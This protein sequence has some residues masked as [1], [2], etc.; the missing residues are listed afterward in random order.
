MRA[1]SLQRKLNPTSGLWALRGHTCRGPTLGA[2]THP[3][4]DARPGRRIWP[5]S[6]IG[7][8]RPGKP[9]KCSEPADLGSHMHIG[10]GGWERCRRS[11]RRDEAGAG[12]RRWV[13]EQH[14][15]EKR[16]RLLGDVGL[17]K[18]SAKSQTLLHSSGHQRGTM[19]FA[20]RGAGSRRVVG[21]NMRSSTRPPRPPSL[22]DSG[23]FRI[24][25]IFGGAGASESHGEIRLMPAR[26]M[27]A[28][29]G[30]RRPNFTTMYRSCKKK[31]PM[32]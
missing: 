16:E 13:S 20:R 18:V 9:Q 24:S 27:S 1:S 19:G 4:A 31:Q 8:S 28:Q 17:F 29:T 12:A 15:R 11:Y 30:D 7:A 25:H 32:P 10:G 6:P 5:E 2:E 23:T 22:P 26:P 3:K 21:V 14:T